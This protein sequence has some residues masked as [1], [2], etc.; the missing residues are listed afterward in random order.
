[1]HDEPFWEMI[2]DQY[3]KMLTE[4]SLEYLLIIKSGLVQKLVLQ[5][6]KRCYKF[7]KYEQ[8]KN[9][10]RVLIEVDDDDD[11]ESVSSASSSERSEA[12]SQVSEALWWFK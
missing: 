10:I 1:M 2:F 7:F 11:E 5:Q 12:A 3:H 8:I 4:R 9:L 6:I